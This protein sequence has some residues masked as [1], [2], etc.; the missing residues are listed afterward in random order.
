MRQKSTNKYSIQ[1]KIIKAV[2][3]SGNIFQAAR[4]S[5]VDYQTIENWR[6]TDPEFNLALEN[7]L[8]TH[9]ERRVEKLNEIQ[10]KLIKVAEEALEVKIYQIKSSST[11]S[12]ANRSGAVTRTRKWTS[13]KDKVSEPNIHAALKT[14][15]ELNKTL[16][17]QYSRQLNSNPNSQLQEQLLGSPEIIGSGGE[18]L[19]WLMNDKID[20]YRIRR[21]QAQTQLHLKKGLITP[22]EYRERFIEEMKIVQDIQSRIEARMR[23]EFDGKTLL[24]VRND[25]RSLLKLHHTLFQK[26]INNSKINR[27]DIYPEFQNLIKEHNTN[28]E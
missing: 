1:S 20:L 7:N 28:E 23:A 16:N 24:E 17:L 13:I 9:F 19:S 27:K 14:L 4:L 22:D 12:F 18:D 26:A 15:A 5:K 3:E 21:L 6:Q 25:V 10:E 8:M 11:E 2:S